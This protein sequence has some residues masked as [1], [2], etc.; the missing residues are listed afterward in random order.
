ML[1]TICANSNSIDFSQ[2]KLPIPPSVFNET[3]QTQNDIYNYLNTIDDY[4]RKA[5][6]IAIEHL[7]TSFDILKSN[8]YKQWKTKTNII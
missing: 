2:I 4:E 5:Y 3:I 1:E 7:K 8:G 6:L